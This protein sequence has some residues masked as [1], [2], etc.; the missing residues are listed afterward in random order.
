MISSLEITEKYTDW[1]GKIGPEMICSLY[2]TRNNDKN[3]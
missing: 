2:Q 3:T 1:I